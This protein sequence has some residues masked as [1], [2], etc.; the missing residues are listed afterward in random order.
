M[1]GRNSPAGRHL[2]RGSAIKF[3]R[4]KGGAAGTL[5]VTGIGLGDSLL[6]VQGLAK[7]SGVYLVNT[8]SDFTSEF[9]VSA[10]NAINNTGGTGTTNWLLL[11]AY[12]DIDG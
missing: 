9:S 4:I 3:A 10:A 7:M 8:T 1:A 5:T 12:D 2:A 11:I 6:A